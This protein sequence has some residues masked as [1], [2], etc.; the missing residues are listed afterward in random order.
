MTVSYEGKSPGKLWYFMQKTKGIFAT[1]QQKPLVSSGTGT[2]V[3]VGAT[4]LITQQIGFVLAYLPVAVAGLAGM[5]GYNAFRAVRPSESDRKARVSSQDRW[6]SAAKYGAG[7]AAVFLLTPV[8]TTWV[9][10][11]AIAAT[12]YFGLRSWKSW[13]EGANSMPVRNFIRDREAEW[14]DH[15]KNGT[16]K[17]RLARVVTRVKNA[18]LGA[19]K[20]LGFTA[21]GT[22]A[23]VGGLAAAQAAGAAIIPAGVVSS[24]LGT[25]TAAAA[26][27]GIGAAAAVYG[28]AA[29]VALAIPAGIATALLCRNKLREGTAA[30][31]N[32]DSKT[33][34]PFYKPLDD[35]YTADVRPAPQSAPALGEKPAAGEF[36]SGAKKDAAP[37]AADKADTPAPAP[38]K[39]E[40]LDP[41]RKAAAEAR[42]KARAQRK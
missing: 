13:K 27:V 40:E 4:Y 37:K 33:R 36:N 8:M 34:K 25:L 14:V 30:N 2:G 24:T 16:L 7:A 9:S 20:W 28:A 15:Q 5:A 29:L 12:G 22:A 35:S 3:S 18:A 19:G 10:V 6:I 11:G 41:M 23:V 31:D 39:K 1:K 26:T 42:R 38:A 21:A 17:K 32:A